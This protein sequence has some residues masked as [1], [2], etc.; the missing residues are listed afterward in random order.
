MENIL[1]EPVFG[2]LISILA[3]W[4][5]K[6]IY[7]K[8]PF[9]VLN[10]LL[11]SNILIIAFLIFFN[12]KLEY[13]EKGGNMIEF[14]LKPATVILAVP[15]YKQIHYLKKYYK[16]I[17]AGITVG[18]ITAVISVFIL[19]KLLKLDYNIIVSL[20]PKSITTP[21]G[22]EASQ[23]NGGIVAVTIVSIVI[24]GITGAVFSP[25]VCKIFKIENKL[26]R[27]IAIGTSSHAL[28]T[29]KA[30]EMGET[31]GA[32][33]SLSIGIAG[34]ITV[35]IIPIFLKIISLFF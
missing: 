7:I 32:M 3:F 14:F 24:T 23:N 1:N 34:L 33:S 5:G 13:Y 35:F 16:A 18:S 6:N 11:I 21:I 15:L 10:P 26:A 27:G 25:I 8:F 4:I 9:S 20:L 12:I 29:S 2:I 31:E 19:A 17:L 30:V 22:V 28:G